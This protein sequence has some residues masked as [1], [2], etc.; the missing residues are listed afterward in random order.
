VFPTPLIE[1]LTLAFAGAGRATLAALAELDREIGRANAPALDHAVAHARLAWWGAELERT[2]A[3]APVH[4]LTRRL[5]G[6]TGETVDWRPLLARVSAAELALA[7]RWPRDARELEERCGATHGAP[8]ALAVQ[9]I[10][11]AASGAAAFGLEL[12]TALGLLAAADGGAPIIGLSPPDVRALAAVRL[13]R[14]DAAQ[15]AAARARLAGALVARA[16]AG[17]LLRAAP[18]APSAF[19]QPWV[20]WRAARDALR[21]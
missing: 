1:R 7:G 18:R 2:H 5:A 12:G 17:E 14:A 19:M 6:A 10:A 15:P 4:P 11:P 16:L 8:W 20:A 13:E 21:E 9:L 3:G